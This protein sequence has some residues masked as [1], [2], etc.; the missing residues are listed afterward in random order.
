MVRLTTK[1]NLGRGQVKIPH[2]GPLL[3]SCGTDGRGVHYFRRS[4][5]KDGKYKL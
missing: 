1:I 3:C 4:K 2:T 5:W